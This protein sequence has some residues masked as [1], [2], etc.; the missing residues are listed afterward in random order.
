MERRLTDAGRYKDIFFT[1]LP[2]GYKLFW[3]YLHYACGD[4]GLWVVD[5]KSVRRLTGCGEVTTEGALHHFNNNG[6]RRI[7]E[8]E[9]KDGTPVWFIPGFLDV[10][11]FPFMQPRLSEEKVKKLD[12]LALFRNV[13]RT[14]KEI[15]KYDDKINVQKRIIEKEIIQYL[16][17][18]TGK[19]FKATSRSATRCIS[20]RMNDGYNLGDFKKV[21]DNMC[22]VWLDDPRMN[23]Y[24]RPETLFGN[25]FGGYLNYKT[26]THEPSLDRPRN[27]PRG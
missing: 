8:L 9:K 11:Y 22:S 19:G 26:V 2:P 14:T 20:A 4:A 15:L 3:D 23:M 13:N 1:T 27:R 16:N 12:K 5:I 17:A 24:L 7:V 18:K 10:Q 25:K 21:I 6:R